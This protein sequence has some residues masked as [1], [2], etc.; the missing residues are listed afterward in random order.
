MNIH[1]IYNLSHCR[2]MRTLELLELF[3][4]FFVWRRDDCYDLNSSIP[5]EL[6]IERNH[7]KKKQIIP[8]QQ[9]QKFVMQWWN[10]KKDRYFLIPP[11]GRFFEKLWAQTNIDCF[12]CDGNAFERLKHQRSTVDIVVFS[13]SYYRAIVHVRGSR[14]YDVDWNECDIHTTA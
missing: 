12:L 6:M 9:T 5:F 10:V 7:T 4:L 11:S 14:S 8:N 13:S 3:L 2:Q 1:Q